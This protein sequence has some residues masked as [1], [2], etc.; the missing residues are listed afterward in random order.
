MRRYK[1]EHARTHASNGNDQ[2]GGCRGRI[3]RR[4][5]GLDIIGGMRGR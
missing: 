3:K 4:G 2:V 1:V 5:G